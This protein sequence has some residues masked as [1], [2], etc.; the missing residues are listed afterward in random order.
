MDDSAFLRTNNDM[1]KATRPDIPSP[2]VERVQAYAK[3]WERLEK[4]VAQESSLKKLFTK[5][6]PQNLC[7]LS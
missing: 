6:Y 3:K 5:T 2:S 1:T 7:G 4:Y